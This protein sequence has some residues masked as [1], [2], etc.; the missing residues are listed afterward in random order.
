MQSEIKISWQKIFGNH[1]VNHAD[2]TSVDD[3]SDA[4]KYVFQS[5]TSH[6]I[7]QG[8]YIFSSEK[9]LHDVFRQETA[10]VQIT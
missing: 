1:Q 10:I 2:E 4:C 3:V 7:N 9:T 6:D 5:V 8:N